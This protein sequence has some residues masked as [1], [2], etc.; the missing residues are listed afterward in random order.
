MGVENYLLA[1]FLL[2]FFENQLNFNLD[3]IKKGQAK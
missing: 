1:R 2:I 3:F